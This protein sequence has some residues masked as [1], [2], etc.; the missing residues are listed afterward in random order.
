MPIYM[1]IEGIDGDVTAEGHDKWIEVLSF[2]W[3]VSRNIGTPTGRAA[4]RETAAPSISD[5]VVT[6]YMDKSSPHLFTEACVGKGKKV[7]IHLCKTA[8][9]KLETYMEYTLTNALVS[10]YRVETSGERPIESVG[11]N[12]T[13]VETKYIPWKPDHTADSPIPAGYDLGLAKKV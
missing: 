10:N 7:E 9:D 4:E 6:K 12:F 8:A 3:V 5:V 2:H 1:K 13:K 11:L